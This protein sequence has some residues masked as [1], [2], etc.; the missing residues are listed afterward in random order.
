MFKCN[1]IY[2]RP[3]FI[4]ST[5]FIFESEASK[6][7]DFNPKTIFPTPLSNI[8]FW[9]RE[10]MFRKSFNLILSGSYEKTKKKKSVY[11]TC[12]KVLFVLRARQKH[13]SSTQ[14]VCKI[15]IL[16]AT[17]WKLRHMCELNEE[18]KELWSCMQNGI[19]TQFLNN[20]RFYWVRE[21]L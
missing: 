9:K 15:I 12:Q 16:S 21:A 7:K 11:H 3:H 14:D 4:T 10:K 8:G 13:S 1:L 6:A 17:H 19:M 20:L 2:D 18:K 5:H